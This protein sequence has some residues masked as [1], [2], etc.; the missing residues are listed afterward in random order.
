MAY[1]TWHNY[2]T[3]IPI[4]DADLWNAL[5][6]LETELEAVYEAQNI[7]YNF[8][9]FYGLGITSV[10]A[11]L[12]KIGTYLAGVGVGSGTGLGYL[13][14]YD[15]DDPLYDAYNYIQWVMPLA[16]A[17]KMGDFW[18]DTP[19]SGGTCTLGIYVNGVL[20]TTIT[21]AAGANQ[22]TAVTDCSGVVYVARDIISLRTIT[23]N[24]AGV[25]L[26]ALQL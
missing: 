1:T 17:L 15:D 19:P 7:Y 13:T 23:V 16:G 5:A 3:G 24:S 10:G 12:N 14:L 21:I 26:A 11:A 20:I 22:P 4:S 8:A 18:V 2:L 9:P 25:L 6:S